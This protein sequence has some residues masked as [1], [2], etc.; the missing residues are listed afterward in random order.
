MS[1]GTP[2]HQYAYG[3]NALTRI[4]HARLNLKLRNTELGDA[5]IVNET[6][7]LVGYICLDCKCVSYETVAFL[8]CQIVGLIVQT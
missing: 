7:A 5:K 6:V 8:K 3:L 4:L 2:G 1:H